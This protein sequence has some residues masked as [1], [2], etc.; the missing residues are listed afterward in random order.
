LPSGAARDDDVHVARVRR[1]LSC[2][3]RQVRL[4]VR[5]YVDRH[6]QLRRLWHQVP[7]RKAVQRRD[8]RPFVP[9]GHAA[10]PADDD[11]DGP[12][13]DPVV[14]AR[15][16]YWQVLYAGVC[17]NGRHAPALHSAVVRQSCVW[18]PVHVLAQLVDPSADRQQMLPLSQSAA[19][20]HATETP[21]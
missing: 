9:G 8:L 3:L 17:A 14:G 7:E 20:S 10:V 5:E 19:S 18:L 21:N 6:Q 13:E 16:V 4:G 15:T 12:E 2:R 11:G 1:G